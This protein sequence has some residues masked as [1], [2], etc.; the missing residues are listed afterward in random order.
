MPRNLFVISMAAASVVTVPLPIHGDM[1]FGTGSLYW[2]ELYVAML[3]FARKR[4]ASSLCLVQNL[5]LPY[6]VNVSS[7]ASVQRSKVESS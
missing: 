1:A 7:D 3:A 5:S 4:N 6:L 2:S